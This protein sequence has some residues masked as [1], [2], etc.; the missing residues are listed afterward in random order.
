MVENY[1]VLDQDGRMRRPWNT[2]N[3]VERGRGG[4]V[5]ACL[6]QGEMLEIPKCVIFGAKVI[7]FGDTLNI[8]GFLPL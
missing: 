4:A 2:K 8:K 6:R 3:N 7:P 5:A 1:G